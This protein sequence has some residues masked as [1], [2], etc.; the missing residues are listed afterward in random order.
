MA[1]HKY[2]DS[3]EKM[4]QLFCEYREDLRNNPIKENDFIGGRDIH[5]VN[6]KKQRPLTLE[7]FEN[8]VAEIDGMPMD[9]G[10]Y[11]SNKNDK[12]VEFSTICSRI[13]RVI[14]QDQIEGGMA[15]IYN[16]SITQRLNGLTDKSQI[17]HIEQP[18]FPD[19]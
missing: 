7:G 13:R 3:A 10:D 18:L 4:W 11:F 9:L 5:E 19:E 14:R 2:I 16:P 1:K 17:E 8:Y 12:Y 15:G 6:R